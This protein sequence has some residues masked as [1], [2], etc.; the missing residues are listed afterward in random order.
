MPLAAFSLLSLIALATLCY[1]LFDIFASQASSRIDA[2]LSAI[3]FNGL[4]ALVPLA[5]YLAAKW[6][7][8]PDTRITMAGFVYSIL[9]GIAIA[10]FSILLIKIFERAGLAYVMPLIY[11][12][13]IA[14]ASLAGWLLFAEHVSWLQGAG[15]FLVVAGIGLVIAGKI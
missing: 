1:T 11:G 2:N 13:S 6:H 10:L 9:A 7:R 12:G 14:L 8:S 15:I 5:A 3:I 4:G